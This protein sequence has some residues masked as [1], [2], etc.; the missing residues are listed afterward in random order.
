MMPAAEDDPSNEKKADN[1]KAH[2][3]RSLQV[4]YGVRGTREGN[5]QIRLQ[6]AAK[7]EAE[8]GRY[9]GNVRDPQGDD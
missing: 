4:I 2:C 1:S 5:C 7:Y 3:N 9:Y 6:N 8:H